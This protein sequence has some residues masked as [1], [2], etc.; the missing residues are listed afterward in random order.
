MTGPELREAREKLSLTQEQ[1][2]GIL[3]VDRAHVSRLERGAKVV[4]QQ[5]ALLI[6]AMLR[7]GL[8]E[9]W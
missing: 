1:L 2:A 9:T 3:D 7:F 6:R 4:T 5:T 8:P